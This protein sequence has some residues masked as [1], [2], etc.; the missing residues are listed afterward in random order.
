MEDANLV[1]TADA[2]TNAALKDSGSYKDNTSVLRYE[3]DD[4]IDNFD[5]FKQGIFGKAYSARTLKTGTYCTPT[6]NPR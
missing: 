2:Y 3:Y 4:L 5:K 1:L 6:S